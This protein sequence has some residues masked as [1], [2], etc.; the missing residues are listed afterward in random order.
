MTAG[1]FP[2]PTTW[3]LLPLPDGDGQLTFPTHEDS[4]RQ[5]IKVILLTRP[6]EQLMH[7]EFGAGLDRFVDQPNTVETRRRIRDVVASSLTRW[8]PRLVLD[9]VDVDEVP[10]RPAQVRVEIGYRI[11]RTGTPVQTGLTVTVGG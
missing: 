6:G 8:E 5:M 7:P 11:R 9:R 10:D 1:A 2:R 4:V 3:P